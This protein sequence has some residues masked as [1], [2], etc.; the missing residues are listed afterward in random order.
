VA[1][2][3][4]NP[5]P[6]RGEIEGVPG[7]L[8]IGAGKAKNLRDGRGVKNKKL[9]RTGVKGQGTKHG[10][11][12]HKKKKKLQVGKVGIAKRLKNQPGNGLLKV[13]GGASKRAWKRKRPAPH[14]E[15]ES[16]KSRNK[17]PAGGKG[18]TADYKKANEDPGLDIDYLEQEIGT[19]KS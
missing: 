3:L 6:I 17:Y 7:L 8:L 9:T 18:S 11:F 10:R 2:G 19:L 14:R 4:G 16:R 15:M 1:Q 13:T 12:S 5:F